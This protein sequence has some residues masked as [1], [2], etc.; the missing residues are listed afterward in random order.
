[1]NK[2]EVPN[3]RGDCRILALL[4]G[5]SDGTI[6]LPELPVRRGTRS[7]EKLQTSLSLSQ[8]CK[9]SELEGT[10]TML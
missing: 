6:D 8:R 10:L 3:L 1:M 7:F 4:Q 2:D 5:C 9:G